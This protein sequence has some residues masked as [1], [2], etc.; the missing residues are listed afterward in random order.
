MP[1]AKSRRSSEPKSSAIPRD[2]PLAVDALLRKLDDLLEQ[3]AAKASYFQDDSGDG[4]L[5]QAAMI[6]ARDLADAW[7]EGGPNGAAGEPASRVEAAWRRAMIEVRDQ[8][9]GGVDTRRP[10]GPGDAALADLAEEM[11]TYRD[12]L[13]RLLAE[14][15]GQFVLVKGAEIAGTFGDRSEAT[16]EGYRRFGIVPFLVRQ[17]TPDEPTVYLPNV[18]P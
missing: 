17:I 5:F 12:N 15:R 13:P 11:I 14:H 2:C 6:A 7:R 10:P 9:R 3:L 16:S 18:V 4:S 8:T 1:G